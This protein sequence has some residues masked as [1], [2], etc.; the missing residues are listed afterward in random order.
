MWCS[1]Y[2]LEQYREQLTD[3][4]SPGKYRY[5]S[6][7]IVFNILEC[8]LEREREEERGG[9]RERNREGRMKGVINGGKGDEERRE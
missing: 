6:S 5:G 9:G 8:E 3:V 2:S 1:T 7:R 4:H